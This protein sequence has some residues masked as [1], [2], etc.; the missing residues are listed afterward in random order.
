MLVN[1]LIELSGELGFGYCTREANVFCLVFWRLS[2]NISH[3][4]VSVFVIFGLL[5]DCI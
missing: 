3:Y 4:N 2:A 5:H 1:M